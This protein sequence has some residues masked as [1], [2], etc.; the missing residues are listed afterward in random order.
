[1]VVLG[2]QVCVDL[3][4]QEVMLSIFPVKALKMAAMLETI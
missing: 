2:G 3:I 4:T 1:M